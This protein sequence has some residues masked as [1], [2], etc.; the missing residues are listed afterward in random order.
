M[1][2]DGWAT[3]RLWWS[4][5]SSTSGSLCDACCISQSAVL[6]EDGTI[7]RHCSQSFT[8]FGNRFSTKQ[9]VYCNHLHKE[10]M[11]FSTIA[12][13]G[14]H[15]DMRGK[16]FQFN[17]QSEVQRQLYVHQ[18]TQPF[19]LQ[20]VGFKQVLFVGAEDISGFYV[21]VKPVHCIFLVNTQT[22]PGENWK[23]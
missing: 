11:P 18:H 20:M 6:L 5:C 22:Q 19:C 17:Q 1:A 4:R 14:R 3:Y 10:Q 9:V 21:S 15:P 16:H 2:V 23:G 8:S 12:H 13:C 7:W